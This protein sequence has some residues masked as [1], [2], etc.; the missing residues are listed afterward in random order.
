LF[1]APRSGVSRKVLIPVLPSERF[2]DAVVAAAD[3]IAVEGGL[4]TFLFTE[5]RP[6]E[7][8]YESGAD[9]RPSDLDVASDSGEHD[10]RDIERWREQQVAA[11]EDARQILYERGIEDDRID[12]LFAD[13]ADHES[14]A[15]AIADEAAAGAHDLVVLSRGCFEDEV[16]EAGSEMREIPEAI[17]A[18]VGDEVRVLVA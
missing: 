8:E 2:Y 17:R 4:A 18:A 13:Y 9:G 3:V 11:L 1:L 16:T 5:V 15:Q 10:G 7:E 12:Y 6:P 14:A